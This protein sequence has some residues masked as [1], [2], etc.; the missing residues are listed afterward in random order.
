[1]MGLSW[2]CNRCGYEWG[3]GDSCPR[4]FGDRRGSHR[5]LLWGMLESMPVSNVGRC[6]MLGE[7]DILTHSWKDPRTRIVDQVLALN[8]AFMMLLGRE[9]L[10]AYTH[11]ATV[12]TLESNHQLRSH[13]CFLFCPHGTDT[14]MSMLP[15][16]TWVYYDVLEIASSGRHQMVP[17]DVLFCATGEPPI[18]RDP[19]LVGPV[20]ADLRHLLYPKMF[21]F[22]NVFG[23]GV[24]CSANPAPWRRGELLPVEGVPAGWRL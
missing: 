17:G 13:G 10:C 1:M 11:P 9:L 15:W 5:E 14:R 18:V 7:G 20:F 19:Q 12:L 21:A 23:D 16:L 6:N 24:A 8:R 2:T 22:A 3:G 4:C